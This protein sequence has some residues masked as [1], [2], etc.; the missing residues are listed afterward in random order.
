MDSR[1]LIVYAKVEDLMY[2]VYPRLQNFPKHEKHSL[3]NIIKENFLLV[4][5]NINLANAVKSKR[6]TYAQTA[7]A[8]L[9][10]LRVI[11]RLCKKRRYFSLGFFE[12]VDIAMTEIARLLSGYIK[13]ARA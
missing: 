7:D 12:Q 9:R 13:S 10:T 1:N 5:S 8:H 6:M 2:K 3:V 11:F 4:L